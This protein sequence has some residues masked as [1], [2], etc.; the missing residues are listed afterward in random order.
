VLDEPNSN[1]DSNGDAALI[2]ALKRLKS[3][4]VTVICV[5]QRAELILQA[6]YILR[7]SQGQVDA[8]GPRDEILARAMRA[9]PAGDD[10][11]RPSPAAPLSV[12]GATA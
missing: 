12:V 11:R 3:Q 1:L 6:D 7:I 8:F 10:N 2:E 4:G 5:A 9:A